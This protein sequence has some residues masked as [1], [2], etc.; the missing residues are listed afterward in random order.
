VPGDGIP[1]HSSLNFKKVTSGAH[2]I[3][4]VFGEA[5]PNAAGVFDSVTQTLTIDDDQDWYWGTDTNPA[6][7]PTE[8]DL[9]SVLLHEAGHASAFGHFGTLAQGSVMNGQAQPDR[10]QVGGILHVI[11]A[12]AVHGALD[13]YAIPDQVDIPGV[14]GVGLVVLGGLVLAVTAVAWRR[15]R[16]QARRAI[17]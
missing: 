13:V 17:S 4:V 8:T 11:D 7:A 3:H 14:E 12:S 1:W 2:E 16:D 10:N 15:E 9:Y 5:G 6:V